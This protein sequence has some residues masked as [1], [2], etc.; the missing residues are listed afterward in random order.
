MSEK[1]LQLSDANFDQE[2]KSGVV[3]V[4]FW[5]DWCG[6]CRIQAPIIDEVADKIGAAAKIAKVNVD[7]S[8]RLAS[9]FG[10]RS[11]PTL[12]IFKDGK[13]VKQFTGVQ[14]ATILIQELQ[15]AK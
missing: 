13:Q 1:V 9:I 2:I 5:A 7:E 8:P 15:A 4:D 11:I 10:I 6:P 14:K 12:I 3:L